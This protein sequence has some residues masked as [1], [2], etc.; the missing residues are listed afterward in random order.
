LAG[1]DSFVDLIGRE[2]GGSMTEEQW[3]S[4]TDPTD[5]LLFLH[6][7]LSDRQARLFAIACC[8]Q[9][10][11]LLHDERSRRAVE[12]AE[13][14]VDGAATEA[15]ILSAAAGAEQAVYDV[16]EGPMQWTAERAAAAAAEWT[17][18]TD[19]DEVAWW[20]AKWTADA[21]DG[22]PP[23]QADL[24]RDVVGNPFRP[25]SISD[26]SISS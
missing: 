7:K 20:A 14:Y 23:I 10:W 24:L 2:F 9:V 21:L 25:D 15:E 8:R 22:L 26:R 11:H 5:M 19:L 17:L 12:V 16:P 18:G 4:S 3:L 13:R 1:L 6:G